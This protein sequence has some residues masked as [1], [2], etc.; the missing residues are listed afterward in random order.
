MKKLEDLDIDLRKYVAPALRW[1][2]EK[3]FKIL[4]LEKVVVCP[5]EGF[6][7]TVDCAV[8]TP[9]GKQAVIDWKTTRTKGK[10]VTPFQGQPEQV[11]A[12]GASYFGV[13]EVENEKVWGINAYISTDEFLENGE[14]RFEVVMYS[15]A[16]IKHHWE[17][18]KHIC[19]LWRRIEKYDPR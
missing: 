1:F 9:D 6:A 14:S 19:E 5:D 4:D 13:S 10:K 15:P 18:F 3:N 12:Y 16:E 2:Q 11:S 8:L 17:T 7:G